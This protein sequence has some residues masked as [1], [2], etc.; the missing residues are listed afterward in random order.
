MCVMCVFSIGIN[1]AYCMCH[2]QSGCNIRL[3][4]LICFTCSGIP[5]AE[6]K[7]FYTFH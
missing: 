4:D 1:K 3:N 6:V 7:A 5:P 2:D